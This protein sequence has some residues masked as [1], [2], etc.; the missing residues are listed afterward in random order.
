MLFLNEPI[1]PDRLLKNV[2]DPLRKKIFRE[3]SLKS[4][5]DLSE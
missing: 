4:T 3:V 2:L 1:F 5:E